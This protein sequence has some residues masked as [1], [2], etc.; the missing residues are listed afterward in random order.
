MVATLHKA[1][2]NDG[3]RWPFVL[4]RDSIHFQ[5]LDYCWPLIMPALNAQELIRG[6]TATGNNITGSNFSTSMFNTFSPNLLGGSSA[7][8]FES[9]GFSRPANPG[10]VAI[11]F[12]NYVPSPAIGAFAFG[13]SVSGTNRISAHCPWSDG[14]LYW[15]YGTTTTGRISTTYSQY[16][17]R[18]THILLVASGSSGSY[19]AIY[20]NGKLITSK[21][22][23]AEPTV[24]IS[25]FGI[26]HSIGGG[27]TT[28]HKGKIID[29]R[30]Y[31]TYGDDSWAWSL[32][33]PSTRW[34]LYYE[35]G[36]RTYFFP[37]VATGGAAS[38]TADQT[39]AAFASTAALEVLD[40]LA[41]DQTLPAF[42]SSGGLSTRSR[43]TASNTLADFVAAAALKVHAKLN[44][45]PT[46]PAVTQ[47]AAVEVIVSATGDSAVPD[48]LSAAVVGTVQRLTAAQQ[49]A[50]FASIGVLSNVSDP[51]IHG[52]IYPRWRRIGRR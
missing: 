7:E 33:D 47:S 16:L 11:T 43:L 35:L 42:V 39:I 26:G 17:D 41:A 30:V 23:S 25:S 37:T 50:D 13:N 29:F 32:H 48:F 21:A 38:L 45:V 36:R 15:D 6:A 34:D 2:G 40:E 51:G 18:W 9:P 19:Q 8:S 28:Y 49:I 27:T 24:D 44:G 20:I 52:G 14:V 4:N 1:W 12:W 22:N 3:P 46:I 10:A 5:N 31:K